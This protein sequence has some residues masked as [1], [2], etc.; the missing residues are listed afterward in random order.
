MINS[1][2]D[3]IFGSKAK[4]KEAENAFNLF[5]YSSYQENI[6]LKKSEGKENLLRLVEFGLIPTQIMSKDCAKREKKSDVLKEKEITDQNGNL[7]VE[8][9]E[10]NKIHVLGG[11]EG[12]KV[13]RNEN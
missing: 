13:N 2:I 5:T 1:W 3:L 12:E 11:V 10:K 7:Q 8:R 6:D 4:G 9:A